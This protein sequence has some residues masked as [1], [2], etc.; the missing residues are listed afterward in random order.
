MNF[1]SFDKKASFHETDATLDHYIYHSNVAPFIAKFFIQKLVSS[2]PSRSY[3]KRV[4]TAF[5]YGQ[6]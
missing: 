3:I 4:A 5:K 1:I 2:N 6:F